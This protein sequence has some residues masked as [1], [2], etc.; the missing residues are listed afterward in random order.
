[1]LLR[2]VTV[3]PPSWNRLLFKVKPELKGDLG[4]RE[5]RKRAG[6]DCR[7]CV[8]E[9]LKGRS[10]QRYRCCEQGQSAFPNSKPE[11]AGLRG[12][13]QK[14]NIQVCKPVI[15]T[16]CSK[17]FIPLGK[18]YTMLCSLCWFWVTAKTYAGIGSQREICMG[19]EADWI[20]I[21]NTSLRVVGL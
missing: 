6:K 17:C 10:T 18:D 11:L 21:I 5:P 4:L 2:E 3:V 1:M 16:L 20:C 14:C 9:K 15:S 12:G 19:A 8:S 13:S 7:V